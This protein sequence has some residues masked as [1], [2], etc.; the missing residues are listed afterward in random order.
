MNDVEGET[1]VILSQKLYTF[2]NS[3]SA[4]NDVIPLGQLFVLFEQLLKNNI[5]KISNVV[6][7]PKA[8]A[9]NLY[10]VHSHPH[11]VYKV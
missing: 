2:P 6:F 11:I 3:H 4:K 7:I 10:V 1:V 9:L 8:S 5:T